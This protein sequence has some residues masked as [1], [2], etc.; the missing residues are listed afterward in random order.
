MFDN[1]RYSWRFRR[2]L[3]DVEET[4]EDLE[5]RLGKTSRKA[6]EGLDLLALEVKRL[7]GRIVGGIRNA[8]EDNEAASWEEVDRQIREGTYQP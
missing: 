7:R 1:I 5:A 8:P 6:D 2:R 3:K 4:L